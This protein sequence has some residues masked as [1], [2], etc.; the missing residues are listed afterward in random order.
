M[1]RHRLRPTVIPGG[2]TERDGIRAA[3]T[4][5]LPGA[6]TA[7]VAYNDRCAVG[8]LDHLDRARITVP[9]QI[10][11]TGYD[12]S[13]LAQ[14]HR[15]NLTTISQAPKEQARLAVAAAIER[16]DGDRTENQEIVLEPHLVVRRSTAKAPPR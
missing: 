15:M 3:E 10:S 12:D 6:A 7:I 4:L 5:D 14:L 11:V 9:E 2:E 13:L 8:V 1:R 16:L